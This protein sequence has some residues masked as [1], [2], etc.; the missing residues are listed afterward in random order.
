MCVKGIVEGHLHR[1]LTPVLKEPPVL[2]GYDVGC[3]P[4]SGLRALSGTLPE[5]K[6]RFHDH[7]AQNLLWMQNV[8]SFILGPRGLAV[9]PMEKNPC[10]NWESSPSPPVCSE[11]LPS[12][13]RQLSVELGDVGVISSGFTRTVIVGFCLH[14]WARSARESWCNES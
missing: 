2:V 8:V 5:I 9:D 11:T 7:S 14:L 6:H 4:E 10:M 3:A 1:F 13:W 12:V